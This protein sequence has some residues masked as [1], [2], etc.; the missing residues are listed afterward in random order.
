MTTSAV[1]RLMPRLRKGN[2]ECAWIRVSAITTTLLSQTNNIDNQNLLDAVAGM[3]GAARGVERREG[4][5]NPR[6]KN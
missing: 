4:T 1:Y 5:S 2:T 6:K 3:R